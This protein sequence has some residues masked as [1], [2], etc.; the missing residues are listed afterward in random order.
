MGGGLIRPCENTFILTSLGFGQQSHSSFSSDDIRDTDD[1]LLIESFGLMH[2][3][4][5]FWFKD[6][7]DADRVVTPIMGIDLAEISL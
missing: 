3:H 6:L 5:T 2:S 4:S 7:R 1:I